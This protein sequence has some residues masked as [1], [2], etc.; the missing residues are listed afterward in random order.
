MAESL[1]ARGNY[2]WAGAV[3]VHGESNYSDSVAVYKEKILEWC[4][5]TEAKIWATNRWRGRLTCY[6]SQPSGWTNAQF[7]FTSSG[8]PQA[9][10]DAMVENDGRVVVVGPQYDLA[11]RDANHPDTASSRLLG[12][13]IG[14]AMGVGPTSKPVYPTSISRNGAVVTVTIHTPVPPLVV[15]TALVSNPGNYGF[16]YYCGS[17]PPAISS[18]DCGAACVGTSCSCAI[19]LASTPGAPCLTD[20]TVRYAYTASVPS[21]PGPTTGPRGNIRDGSG[22][23]DT[24]QG[25]AMHRWM[26]HFEKAVP[27]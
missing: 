18:V 21:S 13:R 7:A 8:V 19:T 22:A 24:W 15:D 17:S 4:T 25:E 1:G 5:D 23:V 3:I 16:T 9:M 6:V 2:D 12:A 27:N 26:V 10:L 14:R 11:Y 20:D